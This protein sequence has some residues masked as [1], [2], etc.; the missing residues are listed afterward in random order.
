MSKKVFAIIGMIA[1]VLSIITGFSVMG[2]DNE[3]S[4][5]SRSGMYDSG[6]TTFGADFYTYSNNNTAEAASAARTT[7]NNIYK[8]YDLLAD[9]FGWLFVFVGLI[10]FCHFGVVRAECNCATPPTIPVVTE[11]SPTMDSIEELKKY[12]V[13]AD[14]GAI[15]QEEFETKKN[16]LLDLK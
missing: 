10:G 2:Q 12:K 5:A 14:S 16:Q 3:C 6:L 9:V 7:A 13:L 11:E 15:T 8:L 4:T 1:C